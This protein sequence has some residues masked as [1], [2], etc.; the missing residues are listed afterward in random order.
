MNSNLTMNSRKTNNHKK[1]KTNAALNNKKKAKS[2]NP[3]K[4]QNK[5]KNKENTNT[6]DSEKRNK[7]SINIL[8]EKLAEDNEQI[9]QERENFF[10]KG[11]VVSR[12]SFEMRKKPIQRLQK[13]KKNELEIQKVAFQNLVKYIIKEYSPDID[14]RFSLQAINALHVA[15]EDFLIALFEDSY[16]CAL[17]AKRVTL[18]QKDMILAKRIRGDFK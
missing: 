7:S 16:L 18:M 5:I 1:Q 9:E 12:T 10:K 6:N 4:K 17:H 3:K 14:F 8:Q 2:Q 11:H 13:K 15:S